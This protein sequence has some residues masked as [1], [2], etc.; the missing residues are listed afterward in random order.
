MQENE[1]N[2][3]GKLRM[4][5]TFQRL[6]NQEFFFGSRVAVFFKRPS[7][8]YWLLCPFFYEEA[9]C[10]SSTVKWLLYTV[11]AIPS[12]DYFTHLILKNARKRCWVISPNYHVSHPRH[13]CAIG[14]IFAQRYDAPCYWL[15]DACHMAGVCWE[16]RCEGLCSK[17][18]LRYRLEQ[19]A[20]KLS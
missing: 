10:K 2:T 15:W 11:K 12:K 4:R 5:R 19:S 7:L 9:T 18:C 20:R 14:D 17:E 16:S 3:T 1:K 13:F 6:L 8:K